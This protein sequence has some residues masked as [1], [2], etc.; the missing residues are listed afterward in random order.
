MPYL[1]KLHTVEET[2]AFFTAVIARRTVQLAKTGELL[3]GY[4]AYGDGWLDHLYIHPS[5]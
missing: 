4:C 2:R 1:P 3:I 5:Y